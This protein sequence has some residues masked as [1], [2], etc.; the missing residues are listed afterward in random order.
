[1]KK[2][3]EEIPTYTILNPEFHAPENVTMDVNEIQESDEDIT[4]QDE[5]HQG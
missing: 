5:N 2:K 3:K 1:M 4:P